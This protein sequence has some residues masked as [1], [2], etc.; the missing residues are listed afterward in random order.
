MLYSRQIEEY[1]KQLY[2]GASNSNSQA[3]LDCFGLGENIFL[4]KFAEVL[5]HFCI[6]LQCFRTDASSTMVY[7]PPCV[8]PLCGRMWDV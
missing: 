8:F 3:Q 4:R 1:F 5:L 7:T 2:L 6:V